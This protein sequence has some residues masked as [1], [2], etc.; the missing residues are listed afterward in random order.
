MCLFFWYCS[1]ARYEYLD[2]FLFLGF[3]VMGFGKWAARKG[4]IGSTA[5]WVAEAFWAALAQQVVDVGNVASDEGVKE[6]IRKVVNFALNARFGGDTSHADYLEIMN[7]Y[8]EVFG[9]GLIGFTVAVLNVEAEF[10]K[11]TESNRKLFWE[12]I[13]EELEKAN[14]GPKFL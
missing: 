5:R 7:Q 8:E 10:M 2:R 14:V 9:P 12:V 6:E 11:N 13:R 3:S 4:S 1:V